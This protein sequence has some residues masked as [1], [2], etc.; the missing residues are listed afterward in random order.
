MK[1]ISR[2]SLLLFSETVFIH[3]H[4]LVYSSVGTKIFFA[5]GIHVFTYFNQMKALPVEVVH[6]TFDGFGV[7]IIVFSIR[8]LSWSIRLM[9]NSY[10]QWILNFKR[11]FQKDFH[12][13]CRLIIAENMISLTFSN[14]F[15]IF[16]KHP[17]LTVLLILFSATVREYDESEWLPT[18]K[19]LRVL[20]CLYTVNFEL[21]IFFSFTHGWS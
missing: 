13:L 16:I 21:S 17:N 2:I 6:R 12:F 7:Q 20:Q 1:V 19:D 10:E 9:I 3:I 11:L 8:C 18:S 4:T 14:E 15:E 5:T